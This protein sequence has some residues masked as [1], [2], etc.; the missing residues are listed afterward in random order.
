[1]SPS[2]A[3]ADGRYKPHRYAE[4]VSQSTPDAVILR[5]SDDGYGVQFRK[6]GGRHSLSAR[7]IIGLA[8]KASANP[9]RIFPHPM[10]VSRGP[11]FGMKRITTAVAPRRSAMAFTVGSVFKSGGPIEIAGAIIR[12]V[13][14][15][16]SGVVFAAG[17]LSMK[18]LT[19]QSVNPN[20]SFRA[21]L[22][23][24]GNCSIAPRYAGLENAPEILAL[25]VGLDPLNLATIRNRV[26]RCPLN[27]LPNVH[28]FNIVR[29][30]S[31]MQA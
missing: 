20:A 8:L 16:M 27:W 2:S 22:K 28:A 24:Q 13:T 6:L 4:A 19:Y 3:F 30:A 17:R 21:I 15:Y 23:A 10:I 1:M 29:T 12:L 26:S 11:S 7:V 31:E 5:G 25:P 18:R 9:L 14:V